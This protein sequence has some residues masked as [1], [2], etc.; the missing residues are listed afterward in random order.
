M[1]EHQYTVTLH[2]YGTEP[3]R[4]IVQLSPSTHY[5]WFELK[6]GTEGGGLWF[7]PEAATLTLQDYDGTA[8]LPRQI[9]AALRAHGITA[10]P[11]FD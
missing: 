7:D 4:G 9:L 3:G 11:E 2:P 8:C 6:D 1:T 10:G 5:G